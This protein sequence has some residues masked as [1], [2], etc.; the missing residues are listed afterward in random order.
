MNDDGTVL[1]FWVGYCPVKKR[2]RAE[3]LSSAETLGYYDTPYGAD[4]DIEECV[5]KQAGEIGATVVARVQFHARGDWFFGVTEEGE[6]YDE[7][8]ALEED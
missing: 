6:F 2:W 3:N 4:D 5:R 7:D 8:D 1:S